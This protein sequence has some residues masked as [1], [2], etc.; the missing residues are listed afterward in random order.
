MASS[1]ETKIILE[2]KHQGL[3]PDEVL[4]LMEVPFEWTGNSYLFYFDLISIEKMSQYV[5]YIFRKQGYS[6]NEGTPIAGFYIKNKFGDSLGF[7]RLP[8]KYN[9]KVE[10]FSKENK[11]CL[12]ISRAFNGS[13]MSADKKIYGKNYLNSELNRIFNQLQFLKPSFKGYMICN[14]CGSYYEIHE[15][16][17]SKDFP[18]K[19]ECSGTFK[20]I[21]IPNSLDEELVKRKI[22]TNPT[23][24]LRTPVALILVSSVCIWSMNFNQNLI[25]TSGIVGLGFGFLLL[26][27]RLKN[28]ELIFNTISRRLIYFLSAVLFFTEAWALF[29]L[30]IPDNANMISAI[31][32][33]FLVIS[34]IFGLGMIFKIISPDNPQNFLDPPLY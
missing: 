33:I 16:E 10:I 5:N 31:S 4:Q 7:F 15:D 19:C 24:Y 8:T 11:T 6:L 28:Q 29:D 14:N 30:S 12:E 32:L 26:M 22:T 17:S 1:L 18:D 13:L 2:C 23:K 34:V 25:A 20:Y 27:I 9:F 3:N 21:A